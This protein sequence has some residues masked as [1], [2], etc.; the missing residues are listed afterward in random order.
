MVRA[1]G[2]WW[3]E[4]ESC[5]RGV[6]L[7]YLPV[8]SL[9]A[10]VVSWEAPLEYCIEYREQGQKESDSMGPL[11]LE[12]FLGLML[13]RCLRRFNRLVFPTIA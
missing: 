10:Y 8:G 7:E 13:T 11:Y 5:P 12:G 6:L 1:L 3:E 2:A 4:G 9:D